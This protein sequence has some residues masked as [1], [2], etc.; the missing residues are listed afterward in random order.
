M[1]QHGGGRLFIQMC[2]EKWLK[3]QLEWP[4]KL[5]YTDED[6]QLVL[7][8]FVVWRYIPWNMMKDHELWQNTKSK[9]DK[10]CLKWTKLKNNFMD[11]PNVHHHS[12]YLL[13]AVIDQ[14]WQEGL[15][16]SIIRR[17]KHVLLQAAADIEKSTTFGYRKLIQ[18]RKAITSKTVRDQYLLRKIPIPIIIIN[19]F[20]LTRSIAKVDDVSEMIAAQKQ[21]VEILQEKYY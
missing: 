13:A 11:M 1:V 4:S 20:C 5:G 15:D 19:V 6:G 3:C 12:I 2:D 18:V 14:I 21:G 17:Y 9:L 16:V 7:S 8:L 10:I